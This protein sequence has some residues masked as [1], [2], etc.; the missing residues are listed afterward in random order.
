VEAARLAWAA[1]LG[2]RR[3]VSDDAVV[4]LQLNL[5]QDTPSRSRIRLSGE[6]DA[7]GVPQASVDWRV[8]ANELATVRGFATWLKERFAGLGIEGIEWVPEV[9]E[10]GGK[11]PGMDDAR[12]AMGGAC[13]GNDADE[14]VV[15]SELTVRGV[16]NLSIASA[17]V[18]PSGSP[19]LPTLPL[20]ALTLRLAERLAGLV[21]TDAAA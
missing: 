5:A 1:K 13:M 19:Q 20:M 3:R 10:A 16:A 12:H 17:A 11:V 6:L 14:S 18:F 2:H 8:T 9:F 4:K 7:F 21:D 15:D